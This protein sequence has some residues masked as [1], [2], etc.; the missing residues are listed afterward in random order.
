MHSSAQVNFNI[1]GTPWIVALLDTQCGAVNVA[2]P[3]ALNVQ[4][5]PFQFL[6][7]PAGYLEVNLEAASTLHVSEYSEDDMTN[8]QDPSVMLDQLRRQVIANIPLND[9]V[10]TTTANR[11]RFI[12]N[13]KARYLV[14]WIQH[15]DAAE[16]KL[17]AMQPSGGPSQVVPPPPLV[18]SW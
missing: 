8:G 13:P 9:T 16:G 11:S 2:S 6:V 15:G 14:A 12:H 17:R 1:A 18:F 10:Y 7:W 3:L 5:F 4:T